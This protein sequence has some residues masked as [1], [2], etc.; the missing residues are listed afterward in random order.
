MQARILPALESRINTRG[1]ERTLWA[2]SARSKSIERAAALSPQQRHLIV[3]NDLLCRRR[4]RRSL[5]HST[6]TSTSTSA[7]SFLSRSRDPGDW[8]LSPEWYGS[9]GGGYGRDDG[10]VVYRSG[11]VEVTSHA[12]SS[13]TEEEAGEEAFEWRVL[14]FAGATRQSVCRVSRR[15]P[16]LMDPTCLAFEYTKTLVALALALLPLPVRRKERER[17]GEEGQEQQKQEVSRV[18][19]LCVGV[20]G[21]SFPAALAALRPD[22]DVSAFELDA[23]VVG[24]WAKMGLV[25]E[26]EEREKEGKEGGE[27]SSSSLPAWKRNLRLE[28]QCGA[29]AVAAVA[30]T[31]PG[32]LDLL[33]VDA[34]DNQDKVPRIFT[35]SS[36]SAFFENASRA[37]G[38]RGAVLV[39]LHCGPRPGPAA[40]LAAMFSFNENE[41]AGS[42][43]SVAFDASKGEGKEAVAVAR[44]YSSALL[45]DPSS[46]SSSSSSAA[47]SFLVAARRQQNAIG[48]VARAGLLALRRRGEGEEDGSDGDND[49]EN[50]GEKSLLLPPPPLDAFS[51]A[52]AASRG[53]A[54]CAV[55]LPFDVGSRANYG[56]LKL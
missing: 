46:S 38:P 15:S 52:A 41:K 7:L 6:S 11:D 25:V 36:D 5:R 20:G 43:S 23:R 3:S 31:N 40:A 9:Q 45:T 27:T 26:G 50:G 39:N 32:S 14:R 13:S 2:T 18:K 47:A 21:G 22:A 1:N 51:L 56:L 16:S 54:A 34:F 42:L 24:S 12:A 4:C 55:P 28:Q 37:L 10:V 8:D 35:D 53:A 19:I 48:V 17:E 30:T 49:D 33:I 29:E 44:A